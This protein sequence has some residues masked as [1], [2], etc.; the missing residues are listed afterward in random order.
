MCGLHGPRCVRA[1]RLPVAAAPGSSPIF[2]NWVQGILDKFEEEELTRCL[3]GLE[4]CAACSIPNQPTLQHAASPPPPPLTLQVKGWILNDG[5][6]CA[7]VPP[8]ATGGGGAAASKASADPFVRL[9]HPVCEGPRPWFKDSLPAASSTNE[10]C[11]A[12]AACRRG[13]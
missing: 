12:E 2:A 13:A 10:A 4:A 8:V 1:G 3:H 11:C 9:R 6:D 7:G 5:A